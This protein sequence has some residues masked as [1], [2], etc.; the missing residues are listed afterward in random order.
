MIEIKNLHKSFGNKKVLDGVDLIIETGKTLVIIGRSGCGKSVLL[1]HIVGLLDPDEGD[2]IFEG[3]SVIN[4]NEKEIY[5]MRK[6]I[7]FLFQSGALF[8]S[9]DV[10]ENVGIALVE[11]TNIP[12]N[13]IRKVV[14]EK[15][16][17]VGL[18]GVQHMKTSDLSGGMKKRVA[19][20]R[21]LVSNPKY[22]LYDE[23]TTGLDPIMSDVI[24]A[25]IKDLAEKL[26]VTSIVVTHDI[27]SVYEVA[28]KVAMMHEGKIYFEG[29]PEELLKTNDKLIRSF[30]HR[31]DTS[32]GK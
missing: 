20:A 18:K 5:E 30:L 8:D 29:T 27:F 12:S 11:N 17:M 10:E 2:V 22:I 21:A 32:N 19:L 9:M 1:K 23:P 15:L 31:T 24:D 13:E 4:M 28:D 3:K 26:K 14:E 6:E 7:G 16:S 25:L